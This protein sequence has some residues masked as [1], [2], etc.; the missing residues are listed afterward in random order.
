MSKPSLFLPIAASGSL[1]L[2]T[3]AGHRIE[4][5]ADGS[6]LSA[7]LPGWEQLGELGPRSWLARRRA[8]V[9]AAH[10]LAKLG[11]RLEIAVA[12]QP[13]VVMG[14]D[15]RPSL[16]ARLAGLGRVQVSLASGAAFLRHG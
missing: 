10:V 7:H 4:L 2:D 16:L 1:Q 5:V 11:L 8:I 3:P 14:A 9:R 15:T 13:A 12:Q 6:T